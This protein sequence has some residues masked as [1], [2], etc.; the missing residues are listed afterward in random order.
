[1]SAVATEKNGDSIPS[2]YGCVWSRWQRWVRT[3]SNSSKMFDDDNE[4][5]EASKELV[6]LS[7][8]IH[9]L[10]KWCHLLHFAHFFDIVDRYNRRAEDIYL[11]FHMMPE[12][13]EHVLVNA[14]A[15]TDDQYVKAKFIHRNPAFL[16]ILMNLN[17]SF[18]AVTSRFLEWTWTNR[19]FNLSSSL[20]LECAYWHCN[21]GLSCV[22]HP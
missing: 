9:F 12:A 22:L 15:H 13:F 8:I 7:F 14:W 1:M 17:H 3:F 4:F 18:Q 6:P 20:F 5:V 19:P 11:H 16:T 10:F 2:H 21:M